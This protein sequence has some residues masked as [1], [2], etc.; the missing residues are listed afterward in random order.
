MPGFRGH[1]CGDTCILV[2]ARMRSAK[3]KRARQSLVAMLIVGGVEKVVLFCF[4]VPDIQKRS[5][6]WHQ[7][8][9]EFAE[10]LTAQSTAGSTS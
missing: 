1:E 8:K 3:L 6:Q 2:T 4:Q 9:V 5:G 10:H 7:F